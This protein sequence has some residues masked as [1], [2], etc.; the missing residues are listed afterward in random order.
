[1][2]AFANTNGGTIYVGLSANK[3]KVPVGI[4]AV[5]DAI[6]VLENEI[7][8]T[9]TPALNI[10]IDAQETQGKTIIRI[11]VPYGENRPYALNDNKIYLRDEAETNLAVRDEI[12][13]LVRQGLVFNGG[14][15]VPEH[16]P[17]PRITSNVSVPDAVL[18]DEPS[19][20]AVFSIHPPRS[21]V[22]IASTEERGGETYYTM[23]DLRNGSIVSNVTRSSARRLWDYAIKQHEGNPL[24][25][26]KVEW[27][28]DIGLWRRYEKAGS[29]RYDLVQKDN[30]HIRVYYGVTE[31]GMHDQW[32]DFLGDED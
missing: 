3:S 14:E 11:L 6:Q 29:I 27:H 32:A 24:K 7:D 26:N 31:N 12:V 21:G 15:A 4:K 25:P 23:R 28:G 2:C 10:E 18:P 13:N 5:N 1:V 22:E 16:Q 20:D 9:I 17:V 19:D 8:R 30:G